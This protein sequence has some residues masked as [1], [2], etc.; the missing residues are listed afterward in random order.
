MIVLIFL[1]ALSDFC[2]RYLQYS[3]FWLNFTANHSLS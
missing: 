1:L 3:C 2:C